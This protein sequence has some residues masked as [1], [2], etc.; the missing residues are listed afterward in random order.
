MTRALVIGRKRKGRHIG[1]AVIET[2][3]RLEAA[4]WT[5]DRSVVRRKKDLRRKTAAAV[6][7]GVETV[8]AVGGDGAVLQVVQR[9]ASKPVALGIVPMGTGNLLAENLSIP[10]GLEP[11]I[12]VV[13]NGDRRVIDLGRVEVDGR[14]RFFSVACGIGFDADV[15]EST[16]QGIKR[17]LGRLA[18]VVR[19][20]AGRRRLRPTEHRIWLD[21]RRGR[22]I[23][24]Q[25][26]IANVGTA[27]SGI[28]PRLPIEPDDG[29]LDLVAIR[30]SHRLRGL[31]AAVQAL[32]QSEEGVSPDGRVLR[33]RAKEIRIET[34]RPRLVEIDGSVV[35]TTPIVASVHPAAL[36]VLV[37]ASKR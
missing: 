29:L 21:D 33:A 28:Q 36:T 32:L 10:I 20:A 4:G 5:V 35:G 37:P 17:R 13:L 26:L 22:M 9:L 15:M 19:A 24:S 3:R 31:V 12:D 34:D 1:A 11:A 27:V 16:G 23:A 30:A 2:Q 18:Y 8:V 14:K 6:E 7:D 25:V